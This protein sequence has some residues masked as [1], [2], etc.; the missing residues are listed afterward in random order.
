MLTSTIF[1]TKYVFI[2]S[3]IPMI[4]SNWMLTNNLYACISQKIKTTDLW[5]MKYE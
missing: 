2:Y 3:H 4:I 5:V 1:R